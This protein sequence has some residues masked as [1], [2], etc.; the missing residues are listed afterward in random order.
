VAGLVRAPGATVA[1]AAVPLAEVVRGDL[2]ESVHLGH[3]V[4]QAG[5][6]RGGLVLGDGDAAIWPRSSVKPLQAVAMLRHGLVLPPRLLALATA[7]H[8]G[9]PVHLAGVR[10]ILA[11]VGLDATALR[12][13]P[14]MPLHPPA[15][16]AWRSEHGGPASLTQNCSGKHAAMLATCVAA[17]WDTATYLDED[18]PLQVAVRD[19]VAELTGVPVE[20]VTVDG[21]GAPL[22]STTVRGI[23]RAFGHLAAA[24]H[25]APGSAE[26]AVAEAMSAFPDMVGGTG[27]DATR[28][29][30]AVPGLVAKD[31]ADGVYGAGLP[32]GSALAFKVLD[33]ASRPRPAVLAAA[34]RRL[35]ASDVP[36]ADGAALAALG[37]V[38]VLGGGRSV[39]TVRPA[40]GLA[41]DPRPEP[42]RPG[43]AGQVAAVEHG[44]AGA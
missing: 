20:H 44:G 30:R 35:G 14:D 6:A 10:E 37:D 28:A 36:G 32:D 11:G 3:L 1:R 34:L 26:A 29:M 41:V 38:A 25:R 4:L 9:E 23:A 2:V 21:C 5:P 27:R 19:T 31:G 42:A 24:P 22:Y 7:S 15:A 12:N 17:G 16:L 43:T 40:S 18:H 8:N 13:T 39:G 33:G